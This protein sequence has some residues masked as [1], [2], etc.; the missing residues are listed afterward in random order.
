MIRKIL[1]I[2]FVLIL[3]SG[4]SHN[5]PPVETSTFPPPAPEKGFPVQVVSVLDPIKPGETINPGGPP[6]EITLRNISPESITSIKVQLYSATGGKF[7]YNYN[8]SLSNPF[9]PVSS[10]RHELG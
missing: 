4:C 8:V 3:T 7:A 5:T 6:I 1:L 9:L 2:L 10:S